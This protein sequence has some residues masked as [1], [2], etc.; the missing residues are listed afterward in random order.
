MQSIEKM[1]ARWHNQ[2]KQQEK[3]DLFS[4]I[5]TGRLLRMFLVANLRVKKMRLVDWAQSNGQ[6]GPKTLDLKILYVFKS[7]LKLLMTFLNNQIRFKCRS[8][9]RLKCV[10]H[11][12]M[13][14]QT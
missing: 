10:C 12:N 9:V 5:A 13:I 8:Q 7:H 1:K 6:G 4:S 11:F 14:P 2:H 3:N